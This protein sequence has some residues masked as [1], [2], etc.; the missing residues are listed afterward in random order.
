MTA[1]RAPYGFW[2]SPISPEMVGNRNRLLDVQWNSDGDTLLWVEERCGKGVLVS[3]CLNDAQRDLTVEQS[4]RGGLSY[5]GGEF[6]ISKGRVI[7]ASGDNRLYT[8]TLGFGTPKP[9]TQPIGS[10]CS[11][12]ISPDGRWIVYGF[13]DGNID[14]IALVDIEGHQWPQKLVQGA[15]FY[16]GMVWHPDGDMLAWI[17]W[18]HPDMPWEATRLKLGKLNGSPPFISEERIIAGD[19]KTPI[20]QPRFSPNG[21]WLSYIEGRG[22]WDDLIL[23]NIKSMKRHVLVKGDHFMLTP[24]AWLQGI[25]TYGWSYTGEEIFHV[26]IYAGVSTLWVTNIVTSES[27]LIDISP[28]TWIN[29]L[30]VSPIKREVAFI[31]SCP[32]LPDRI[33]KWDGAQLHIIR[34][35]EAEN[36]SPDFLPSAVQ[37]SWKSADGTEVYGLFY[38]PTSPCYTADDKPPVIINIHDGPTTSAD[39]RYA[40]ERYYFTS[41]GY[42]WM[43]V[44][45][46]GSTGYG[47]S[48]EKALY[49]N[50]GDLDVEDV[51]G[52]ANTLEEQGLVNGKQL[53]LRGSSAG[54]FTLLNVIC[55]YPERFKSGICLYGIS[56][57]FSLQM[58]THKFELHYNDRLIGTL[59]DAIQKFNDRSVLFHADLIKTPLALFQGNEDRVVLPSQTEAIADVLQRNGITHICQIYQ[60]EGHGFRKIETITDCLKRT[61]RFLQQNVLFAQ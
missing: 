51:V 20:S 15:D 60:G 46:H 4:V 37:I 16:M 35:S 10:V 29:Q 26:R 27:K 40:A 55:R 14:L 58:E 22:E 54:G 9:I 25:R 31:A 8:R 57:L 7:F 1:M 33:V 11:P 59:P 43:E 49:G 17:E 53:I 39:T 18:D 38:P 50:W 23:L 21:E 52:A 24:P 3:K 5:G 56:N 30:A 6:T 19:D 42:A 41:R 13:S 45:Y 61:E 2:I 32:Q 12:S 44:N 48:F 34:R 36:I 28:Y 47:R